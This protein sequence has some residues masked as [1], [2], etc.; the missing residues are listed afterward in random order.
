MTEFAQIIGPL[1]QS[2]LGEPNRAMSSITEL[3][4]GAHGSLSVD[5]VNGQWFDHEANEGGGVL[6][7]VTRETQLTGQDRLDWLKSRGFVFE[8]IHSNGGQQPRAKIVATY[9]YTDQDGELLFQV[10]RFDPKDF[11]Q[12]RPDGH[13]GWVWS[14]KGVK[15]VPYR[16][17][18]LMDNV[19]RVICIVEG[20]RDVDRLWSIGVPATCN[21]GGAGKWRDEL[22]EYF[23]GADVVIIPDRDPQKRHPK[24][25]APMCHSDGRP[26]LP[27]QDHAQAVAQALADVATKVRVLELWKHWPEMPW[28]GDV[29]DWISAG[30]N[31][32][33]LYA[34]IEQT[35]LWAPSDA[36]PK[37]EAPPTVPVLYPFPI[38]G[39]AI[40]RRQ[41]I[42]PGL[43]L[44]RNVTVLV[45]PPGS[46]KSLLT[47]QWGL[48][49]ATGAP[50][51]GWRPRASFKTLIIN[52]EDD[53]DE[54]CRR[55][56][57]AR[58]EMKIDADTELRE[59]VAI[60]ENP[61][62]IIIAKADSRSKTVVRTPMVK[63]LI[64][65]M[66]DNAFDVLVVD[67][68]AE[69]FEGDENSNS[70]LK[71]AAVL[72]RE[73]ARRTNAAVVLVHHTRKFGA[74]AGNMDSARGGGA[75]VGV[76]R[77]VSTL[78]Q[79]TEEE[80]VIFGIKPD[81]RHQYLRFD[82]AKANLTLVTFTARWFFKKSFTLPN[83]SDSEPGDEIGVLLPWEPTTIFKRVTNEMMN[84][85]LDG[86]AAGLRDDKGERDLFTLTRKGRGNKRW[87]GNII[88]D[89]VDC[90]DT[91]AQKVLDAWM[92]SGLLTERAVAT[93]TSKG[94][95]R[96][97][98]FV[99]DSKRPGKLV[100]EETI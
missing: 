84:Q 53:N 12:R 59:R 55:L 2:L 7:L 50:W 62:D 47:L 64:Q 9:D 45:A 14:V 61:S 18:R 39:E 77:T 69:T 48:M 27:G 83:A 1:A 88:H 46:G 35:P 36:S 20:E 29:S 94:V 90:T 15:H 87:A 5:L 60:A 23:R 17:P 51:N 31:A 80:A 44:R 79:M 57:A 38:E 52:A 19:D 70:E 6:D 78:F 72:W 93:T 75:L 92:K 67:P 73:I 8:T 25:G 89:V 22:S 4:Y 11:R 16:L 40:A 54:M 95:K 66:T 24:T 41:W 26:I 100:S 82:D 58:H 85:M 91:E 86:I 10:C 68:F 3:R 56:Y 32:E 76:A 63:R 71:W 30:G 65:T 81:D 99:N 13:G 21:P 49:L 97:G 74:E 33:R 34:L 37:T 98:L 42:V 96:K 28:K 43:L